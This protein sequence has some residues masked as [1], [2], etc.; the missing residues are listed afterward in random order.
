M[1]EVPVK[2]ALPAPRAVRVALTLA[3]ICAAMVCV[4]GALVI[5]G[6]HFPLPALHQMLPD[7]RGMA[8][9]A[10]VG[11][12]AAGAGLLCLTYRGLRPFAWLI[13]IELVLLATLSL[14]QD[15]YGFDLGIDR[16]LI[17]GVT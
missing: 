5:A 13:G 14:A 6:W 11:V 10:A 15:L 12:I 3:R 2:M 8:P 17:G 9:N 16:A 4:I 1:I 7:L